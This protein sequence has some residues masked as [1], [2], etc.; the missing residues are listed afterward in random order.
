[1]SFH[2]LSCEA[3]NDIPWRREGEK[4][5]LRT[6]NAG[7]TSWW[8]KISIAFLANIY[9][10]PHEPELL[11]PDTLICLQSLCMLSARVILPT[12]FIT[13]SFSNNIFYS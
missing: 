3:R 1:M 10:H 4:V 12:G 7:A 2:H 6:T 8:N 11:K 13:G 5:L 9:K